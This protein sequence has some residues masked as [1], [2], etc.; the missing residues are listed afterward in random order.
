MIN[1]KTSILSIPY[2]SSDGRVKH[3][4]V[5]DHYSFQRHLTVADDKESQ[6]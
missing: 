2:E 5:D 1:A 3:K 6:P 4:Q